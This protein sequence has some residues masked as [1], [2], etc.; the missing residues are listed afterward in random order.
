MCSTETGT[1]TPMLF[2]ELSRSPML[3]LI[4]AGSTSVSIRWSAKGK[5][6][7]ESYSVF[8]LRISIY[9]VKHYGDKSGGRISGPVRVAGNKFDRY[10]QGRHLDFER[11]ANILRHNIG[12]G[13]GMLPAKR[14]KAIYNIWVS[15]DVVMTN[16]CVVS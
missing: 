13:K 3:F 15:K 14:Y 1:R 4:Q 11:T 6:H 7:L 8:L 12:H 2:R 16:E 9:V 5:E 10:S